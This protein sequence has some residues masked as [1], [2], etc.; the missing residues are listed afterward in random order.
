MSADLEKRDL[1][2]A[3]P[4]AAAA[5]PSTHGPLM[6]IIR[7]VTALLLA[8]FLLFAHGCHGDEDNEL[9]ARVRAW[10]SGE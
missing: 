7:V 4:D 8:G 6:A 10:A 3:P 2:L 5:L 1:R 9:F